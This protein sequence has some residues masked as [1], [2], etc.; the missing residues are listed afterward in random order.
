MRQNIHTNKKSVEVGY[1]YEMLV[2][3]SHVR[4]YTQFQQHRVQTMATSI[5]TCVRTQSRTPDT[6]MNKNC[7]IVMIL[8]NL[9]ENGL[10]FLNML[11]Q[12]HFDTKQL[13]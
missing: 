8:K 1:K 12:L 2:S 3:V 5:K 7:E 11:E 6:A 10:A 4:E 13:S 9:I